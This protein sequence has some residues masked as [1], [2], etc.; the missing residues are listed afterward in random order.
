M[1]PSAKLRRFRVERIAA[2]ADHR[3][4][5]SEVC[6]AIPDAQPGAKF[7]QPHPDVGPSVIGLYE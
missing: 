6:E 1:Q 5:S 3:G 7:E 4:M 2:L